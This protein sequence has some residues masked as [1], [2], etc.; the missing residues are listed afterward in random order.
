MLNG[1]GGELEVDGDNGGFEGAEE[2]G[3]VAKG[4]QDLFVLCNS[5]HVLLVQ[6][7]GV[8]ILEKERRNTGEST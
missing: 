7:G 8:T 1:H 3:G 6:E 4:I 2:D 5:Y